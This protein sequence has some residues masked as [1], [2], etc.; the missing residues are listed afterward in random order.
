MSFGIKKI[1]GIL[2]LSLGLSSP[3]LS[4]STPLAEVIFLD[5][6]QHFNRFVPQSFGIK[7]HFSKDWNDSQP[8]LSAD[9]LTRSGR[10]IRISGFDFQSKSL[11]AF[12]LAVCHEIGHYLGGPPFFRID[13]TSIESTMNLTQ[14][15]AEGQADYFSSYC[16]KKYLDDFDEVPIKNTIETNT[17]IAELCQS[18]P[19]CESIVNAALDLIQY[20]NHSSSDSKESLLK[21][22]LEAPPSTRT[23]DRIHE[24]PDLHCRLLTLIQG[25][26]CENFV[27]HTGKG[28]RPSCWFSELPPEN[29]NKKAAPDFSG[30]AQGN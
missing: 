18:Q 10:V 5:E 28:V 24:Y 22:A 25:A 6:I 9:G 11:G 8:R 16:L 7:I 26:L 1:L 29:S 3:L 30:A 19:K 21:A 4:D 17:I 13:P 12:R 20:L 2:F 15:S 23:L 27:C 14:L